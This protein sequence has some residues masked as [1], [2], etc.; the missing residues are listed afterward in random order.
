MSDG[1]IPDASIT[2]SST[3]NNDSNY[4]PYLARLNNRPSGIN[5]S[6]GA[7]RANDSKLLKA[8]NFKH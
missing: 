1:E 6:I 4:S 7:W 2:A 3:Y 8:S 5:G